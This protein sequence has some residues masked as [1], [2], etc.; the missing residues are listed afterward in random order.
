MQFRLR[1][2]LFFK[3]AKSNQ[4]ILQFANASAKRILSN[5]GDVKTDL[6]SN[7][8]EEIHMNRTTRTYENCLY[9]IQS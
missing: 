5:L 3:F 1:V 2:C 7:R 8:R 9:K 4:I 6:R